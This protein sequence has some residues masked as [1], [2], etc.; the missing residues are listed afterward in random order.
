MYICMPTTQNVTTPTLKKSGWFVCAESSSSSSPRPPRNLPLVFFPLR[1]KK[2]DG[3]QHAWALLSMIQQ[4]NRHHQPNRPGANEQQVVL[5]MRTTCSYSCQA[6]VEPVASPKNNNRRSLPSPLQHYTE[7]FATRCKWRG[8][9][10]L[11]CKPSW[12]RPYH[13]CCVA[14]Y[15]PLD[16]A[17]KRHFSSKP[18]H[19]TVLNYS[20][21]NYNREEA[22]VGRESET[23]RARRPGQH[24]KRPYNHILLHCCSTQQA[25]ILLSS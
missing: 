17:G 15:K 19:L 20:S 13:T 6:A 8:H 22:A 23:T 7:P 11:E 3:W 5:P 21:S 14:P 10:V 2:L 16:P 25:L 24:R 18:K 4:T 12:S 1:Q 9:S